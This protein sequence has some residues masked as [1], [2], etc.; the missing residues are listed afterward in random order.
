MFAV[1]IWS[2]LAQHKVLLLVAA[3]LVTLVVVAMWLTTGQEAE[4]AR[5]RFPRLWGCWWFSDCEGT[6]WA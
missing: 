6:V 5:V 1:R 2:I 4:L 3:A